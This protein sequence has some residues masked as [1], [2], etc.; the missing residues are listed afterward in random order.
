MEYPYV[1]KKGLS[2]SPKF[3]RELPTKTK[4]LDISNVLCRAVGR[5]E[6]PDVPVVIRWA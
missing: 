2:N 3:R 4:E 1:I 5:S 6:N